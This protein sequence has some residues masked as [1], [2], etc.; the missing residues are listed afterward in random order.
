MTRSYIYS[1]LS[2]LLV[3]LLLYPLPKASAQV[4]TPVISLLTCSPSDSAPYLMYGHSALRV[5]SGTDDLVF[6][7]GIFSFDQPNFLWNFMMGKPIYM[8]GV[9]YF[10][11]FIA[12]YRMD[13]A[14]VIEQ[15]LALNESQASE[16]YHLLKEES[17][18][19]HRDY[20]YN[21][22]FNNCATKPRDLITHYT[23]GNQA[24]ESLTNE[25]FREAIRR[26]HGR[27]HWYAMGCDLCLG[28]ESDRT[29]SVWESC[30]LPKNLS[31]ALS[32]LTLNGG[33]VSPESVQLLPHTQQPKHFTP[34]TPTLVFTIL[35]VL[36]A[37][38]CLYERYSLKRSKIA[39][40]S[41]RILR[42][43][44]YVSVTVGGVVLWFLAIVSEHPHTTLNLNLLLFH[45]IYIFALIEI[46]RKEVTKGGIY[47]YF[48]NFACIVL[49]LALILAGIQSLPEGIGLVALTLLLDQW[50][51]LTA[52]RRRLKAKGW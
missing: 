44:L 9:Q 48:V 26:Q 36:F 51:L 28:W 43:L 31:M 30:F 27:D 42:S 40:I 16:F 18:P 17:M 15:P 20:Q 24:L 47:F 11:D 50:S 12:A 22:Y 52:S 38:L 3:G 29:M 34:L 13:G 6:N 7:Y 10:S 5:R 21:F 8:L 2:T 37:A 49:Y 14:Q 25:T 32:E 41:L 19:E 1:L 33:K 23:N 4:D 46:W 45:P 39:S 35:L